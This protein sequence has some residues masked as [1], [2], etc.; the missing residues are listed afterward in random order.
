MTRVVGAADREEHF[1]ECFRSA[2]FFFF[3][4]D[5]AVFSTDPFF[6][7]RAHLLLLNAAR[8]GSSLTLCRTTQHDVN[9]P[10]PGGEAAENSERTF[11]TKPMPTR[12]VH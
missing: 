6:R 2:S 11:H 12:E 4:T 10:F 8:P 3:C 7:V 1:L 5:R 9:D